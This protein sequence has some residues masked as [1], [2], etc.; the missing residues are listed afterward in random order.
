MPWQPIDARDRKGG[1]ERKGQ[2]IVRRGGRWW[3]SDGGNG[4]GE[5]E[6][7]VREGRGPPSIEAPL[8]NLAE[9]EVREGD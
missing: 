6:D 1:E 4:E 9:D 3:V 2:W 8:C 7:G 5:G